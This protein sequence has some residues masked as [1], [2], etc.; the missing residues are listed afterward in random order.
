M[1]GTRNILSFDYAMKNQLRSKANFDIVSGFLSELF[2]RDVF[3]EEI[4]ESESNKTSKDDK[5]NKVDMLAKEQD[6]SKIIIELQFNN[7]IDFFQ[8]MLYATS[9]A[10]TE[11]LHE[12]DDYDKVKKI[13]SVNI[14][15]FELGMGKDYI[16]RGTTNFEGLHSKD[17][18]QLSEEQQH[19]FLGKKLPAD[20]YPEYYILNLSRFGGETLDTLDEWVDYLKTDRVRDD[21]KAKGLAKAKS[22]LDYGNLSES[23]RRAYDYAVDQR[24]SLRSMFKTARIEGELAGEARGREEGEEKALRKVVT[25]MLSQGKSAEDISEF[26]DIPLDRVKDFSIFIP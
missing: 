1:S 18:L 24:R 9:K 15:Y 17:T 13:Y 5:Y 21:T 6:G 14:M 23:E 12:S 26:L 16:Y 3:I 20:L 7:E 11:S 22:V 2:G 19:N 10:V 25:K 4:L 8:R